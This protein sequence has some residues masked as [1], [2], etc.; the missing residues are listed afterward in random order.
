MARDP[1]LLLLQSTAGDIGIQISNFVVL[2]VVIAP[3]IVLTA[4]ISKTNLSFLS[5]NVRE[6]ELN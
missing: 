6:L 1:I 4:H 3:H 5:R 2:S